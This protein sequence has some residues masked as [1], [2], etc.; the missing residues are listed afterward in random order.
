MYKAVEVYVKICKGYMYGGVVLQVYVWEN[1]I[2]Q[3]NK[4]HPLQ[5]KF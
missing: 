5:M 1:S 4:E 3:I 2:A